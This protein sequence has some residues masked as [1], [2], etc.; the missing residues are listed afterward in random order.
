MKM[1][2]KTNFNKMCYLSDK[3]VGYYKILISLES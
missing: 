3:N 1:P 2:I